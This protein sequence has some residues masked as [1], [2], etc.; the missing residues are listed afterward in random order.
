MKTTLMIAAAAA[1]LIAPGRPRA[2][3]LG[4]NLRSYIADVNRLNR[5][6]SPMRIRG[7]CASACSVYLG[8]RRVCVEGEA[9][10]WFHAASLPG[11]GQP[12]PTGSLEMLAMYPPAVRR[13]AIATGAL[14]QTK[15]S[16]RHRLSGAQ[17]IA[18]G[19]ARCGPL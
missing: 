1:L 3:D 5:E 18:M 15:W 14:E 19:V 10:V 9:E 12:D 6:G 16:V 13:W 11:N 17:L 4:G 8:V 2:D 7:R